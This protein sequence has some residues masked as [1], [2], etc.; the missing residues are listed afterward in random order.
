MGSDLLLI[1]L[2]E[3]CGP[4]P[5]LHPELTARYG[6]N[7]LCYNL[8]LCYCKHDKN[9]YMSQIYINKW[10]TLLG[11]NSCESTFKV[12]L[13][14]VLLGNRK[15]EAVQFFTLENMLMPSLI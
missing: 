4:L 6:K 2:P 1:W 14:G 10:S 8:W 12:G 11:S 13:L 15:D 5:L 7:G 3:H 9:D